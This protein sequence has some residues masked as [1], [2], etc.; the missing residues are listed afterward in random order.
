MKMNKK[1]VFEHIR[2]V[3]LGIIISIG[4]FMIIGAVGHEDYV[5][6]IIWSDYIQMGV[7]LIITSVGIVIA[8]IL[9]SIKGKR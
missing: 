7:G 5:S 4:V 1:E 6:G 3:I 9:V 2:N 8:K